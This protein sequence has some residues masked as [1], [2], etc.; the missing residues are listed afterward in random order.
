VKPAL[1]PTLASLVLALLACKPHDQGKVVKGGDAQPGGTSR[2]Q[3]ATPTPRSTLGAVYHIDGDIEPPELLT[4][5]TTVFANKEEREV[6]GVAIFE[7]V[8]DEAGNVKDVRMVVDP[9]FVPPW[10]E[11]EQ[12]YREAMGKWKYKPAMRNGKPVAVYLTIT[13]LPA[14][15]H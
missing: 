12:R 13:V 5:E 14:Y 15:M 3:P 1:L 2:S 6:S 4:G 7:A 9:R 10:P 8:I 11:F